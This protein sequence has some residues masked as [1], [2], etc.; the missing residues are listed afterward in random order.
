MLLAHLEEPGVLSKLTNP[1]I[2]EDS[3]AL[4][5]TN[6]ELRDL[7][8]DV[9]GPTS[10]FLDT[11]KELY[12]VPSPKLRAECLKT[13]D[14]IRNAPENTGRREAVR[15]LVRL[16]CGVLLWRPGS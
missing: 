15:S 7:A 11:K 10:S 2:F 4:L 12:D 13:V 6:E 9:L 1:I 14:A 5:R 16:C 3:K 8:E